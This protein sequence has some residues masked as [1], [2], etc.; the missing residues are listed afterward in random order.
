MCHQKKFFFIYLLNYVKRNKI[1]QYVVFGVFLDLINQCNRDKK[2]FQLTNFSAHKN[3]EPYA[4]TELFS[5]VEP[6]KYFLLI[7]EFS[8]ILTYLKKTTYYA[9]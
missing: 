1:V 9:I 4:F 3:F 6:N 2:I 7:F 8:F 5:G